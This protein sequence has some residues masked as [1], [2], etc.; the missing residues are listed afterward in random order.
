[1]AAVFFLALDAS[2]GVAVMQPCHNL[3]P[4]QAAIFGLLPRFVT[5]RVYRHA[6]TCRRCRGLMPP[7][8]ALS[9]REWPP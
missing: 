8:F 2:D 6:G 5:L 9:R 1:M 7:C 4:S 3:Y